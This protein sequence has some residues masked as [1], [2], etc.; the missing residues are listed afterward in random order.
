MARVVRWLA[1][2]LLVAVAATAACS[3]TTDL[4]GYAGP[5]DS[6][7]PDA[8]TGSETSQLD[9]TAFDAADAQRPPCNPERTIDTPLA[10]TLGDWSPRAIR[11]GSYPKV[12]K[13]QD[14]PAAV[15]YPIVDTT[16]F[17]VD[18]MNP[19]AGTTS[20]PERTNAVSG[21]WQLSPLALRS[22]DVELEILVRCTS[23]DSCADG[24]A[25]IW[26]DTT[27]AA[28]LNDG[29]T[30]HTQGIPAGVS[31]GAVFLDNF[32]NGDADETNDPATP[33]LEIVKID[34]TKPLGAYPW[35]VTSLASKFL[36]SWHKVGISVR[37][38]AVSV[39]YD[40]AVALTANVPSVA[41]GLIGI[42]GGT[43]GETDAVAVR[44]VKGTF[45]ACTP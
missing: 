20:A 19:D 40:G 3:L 13:F 21:I 8:G 41:R 42:S 9:A 28:L 43:G 25:F 11:N 17:P 35:V 39:R 30:G 15:L 32:H 7:D 4:S 5:D 45:Y 2:G 33:A 10:T 29:G 16:P 38:D 18:P 23:S 1:V 34:G 12:E 26:L 44:N 22:F 37:G 27:N 24:A 14:S 31:G 36:G 6:Q